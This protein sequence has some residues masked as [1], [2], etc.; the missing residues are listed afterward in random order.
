[1][2]IT[3]PLE[4][5][6]DRIM[7]RPRNAMM[8][9]AI[10]LCSLLA[11][12]SAIGQGLYSTFRDIPV[13]PE[14]TIEWIPG[15]G[16]P[17]VPTLP[18]TA[19]HVDPDLVPSIVRNVT[20]QLQ[21]NVQQQGTQLQAF[22]LAGCKTITGIHVLRPDAPSL[23]TD[24]VTVVD[25]S[26]RIIKTGTAIKT[27]LLSVPVNFWFQGNDTT[28]E[29]YCKLNP[30]QEAEFDIT[31][32]VV[33]SDGSIYFKQLTYTF[34]YCG[35]VSSP[36][37]GSNNNNP[38][39]VLSESF[40][41]NVSSVLSTLNRTS[42]VDMS[43]VVKVDPSVGTILKSP[44]LL[45]RVVADS[46]VGSL[47]HIYVR[48]E[49]NTGDL[50]CFEGTVEQQRKYARYPTSGSAAINR[51]AQL[52]LNISDL[53]VSDPANSPLPEETATPA[54]LPLCSRRVRRVN[55]ESFVAKFISKSY[56]LEAAALDLDVGLCSGLCS[57][58]DTPSTCPLAA[59]LPREKY[60]Y[61]KTRETLVLR[62][63]PQ[64]V[65]SILRGIAP[66]CVRATTDKI[67]DRW[68]QYT[69]FTP[70][71]QPSVYQSH[72]VESGVVLV[73]HLILPPK[74]GCRCL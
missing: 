6:C 45:A 18:A 47:G 32:D 3:V 24:K 46:S 31:L 2:E 72:Y 58:L 34:S 5:P 22:G 37:T 15:P 4:M 17:Q 71:N 64:D 69:V 50:S 33:T 49:E 20:D 63:Q 66:Q 51:A 52:G 56:H 28:A 36:H 11:Q 30:N 53:I 70:N 55:I 38:G 19:G 74:G 67:L 68:I 21:G 7:K 12:S 44:R 48:G 27:L 60:V 26:R 42:S 43:F 57:R 10:F 59:G 54:C 40:I 14:L 9:I 61:E 65:L 16:I 62:Q 39:A 29:N 35:I 13:D 73:K 8:L 25:I 1:M 23:V 41:F